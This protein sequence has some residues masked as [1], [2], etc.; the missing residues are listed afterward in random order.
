MRGARVKALRREFIALIGRAPQGAR[1]LR[2]GKRKTDKPGFFT[3]WV[4]VGGNEFRP[5]KKRYVRQGSHA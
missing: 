1:V 5:L 2:R 3:D 4:F